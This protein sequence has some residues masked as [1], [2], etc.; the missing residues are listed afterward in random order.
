VAEIEKGGAV[1]VSGVRIHI[2]TSGCSFDLPTREAK[3][4]MPELLSE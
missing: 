4:P 1:A 3:I 2:L